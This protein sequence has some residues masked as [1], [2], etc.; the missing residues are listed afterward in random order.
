RRLT[1]ED[2]A[3]RFDRLRRADQLDDG[4]ARTLAATYR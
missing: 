2:L 4:A 1:A 3:D